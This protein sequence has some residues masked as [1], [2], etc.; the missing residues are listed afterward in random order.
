MEWAIET[1]KDL[2]TFVC[3]NWNKINEYI[4][5]VQKG[6]PIP[7]YTSVDIRESKEKFAPVDNNLYPAGFNNI[8]ALDLDAAEKIVRQILKSYSDQIKTIGIIPESNT[9]NLFYLDHLATLGKL[10]RNAGFEV[11]FIS[12]NKNL[13]GEEKKKVDLISHSK[14][15]VSISLTKIE[16]GKIFSATDNKEIDFVILN[17]DQSVKMDIDWSAIST[18][19]H[20][21][22]L[23]GWYKRQKYNHFKN[24]QKVIG[25]FS[26]EFNINPNL[27]MAKFKNVDQVDYMSKEGLEN[28]AKNVEDLQKEIPNDTKIF[29]KASQGTYGMGINVISSA[30]EVLNMN[31]KVRNKMD[32][33]KNKIKF[34]SVLIQ[35]G[36]ETILKYDDMPA[37]VTIYLMGGKSIGGFMRANSIKDSNSN[38]NAKGMVFKKYCISEI[39]ENQDHNQKEA[40]YSIIARLSTV[41][42]AMEIKEV[43]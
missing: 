17:N 33:G 14:F 5:Q 25:D 11:A 6:L 31:R 16:N 3:K 38:L 30:E 37:E 32:V 43:L 7:F 15:D 2:E 18:P 13:F 12:P 8:C 10:I 41:A 19:V 42:S 24:Y 1:K 21:T 23:I 27:L 34:T 4:D 26:S 40:I 20:P 22:P 29:L 9:K 36:I 35:E 28:L 39:R